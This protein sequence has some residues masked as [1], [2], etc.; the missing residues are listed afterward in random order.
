MSFLSHLPHLIAEKFHSS[1]D[2][3]PKGSNSSNQ[4]YGAIIFNLFYGLSDGLF[5]CVTESLNRFHDDEGVA[6][7]LIANCHS[8]CDF[9]SVF[10]DESR[11]KAIHEHS[12]VY[13]DSVDSVLAVI[14][15]GMFAQVQKYIFVIFNTTTASNIFFALTF[16]NCTNKS[17]SEKYDQNFIIRIL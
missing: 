11:F 12:N 9:S 14:K 3:K 16:N 1:N 6:F 2:S 10:A 7:I 17:N 15:V 4:K 8:T 5:K 13:V